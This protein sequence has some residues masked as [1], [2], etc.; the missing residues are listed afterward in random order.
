LECFLP[1]LLDLIESNC[2]S[3]VINKNPG[4]NILKGIVTQFN[5]MN[6]PPTSPP[7]K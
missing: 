5:E 2:D 4:S 3:L 1:T 7:Y 6:N